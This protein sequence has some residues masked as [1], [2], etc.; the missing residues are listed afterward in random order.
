MLRRTPMSRGTTPL[1][2]RTP[3]APVSPLRAAK[4][5]A[6]G[7]TVRAFKAPRYTGPT[8]EVRR[9][10]WVRS[11]GICE[12]PDCGQPANDPHHRYERG[13]GGIGPKG[14]GWV[15]DPVNILAA[16][17]HHND[18][19]SNQQPHEA[20]VMGWRLKPGELPHETPVLA[21]HDP[22]PIYLDNAGGWIRYEDGAA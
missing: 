15:N 10:V 4:A 17:R 2:R 5:A 18:W 13:N 6:A 3:L 14:P 19:V 7:K 1:V 21:A 9:I 12:M 8:D 20:W 16:C 22:E 11:G